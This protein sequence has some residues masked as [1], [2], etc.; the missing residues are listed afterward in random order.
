MH[1]LVF[2]SPEAYV[3]GSALQTYIV[4][5]FPFQWILPHYLQDPSRTPVGIH[6][7]VRTARSIWI[8][9]I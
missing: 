9:E 5:H 3:F 4:K 7:V 2:H 8:D 1:L 6:K